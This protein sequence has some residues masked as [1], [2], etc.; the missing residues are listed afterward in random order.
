MDRYCFIEQAL[1]FW[2][3]I[4]SSFGEIK[5]YFSLDSVHTS[6]TSLIVYFG[7]GFSYFLSW[8]RS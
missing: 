4:G 1:G 3:G 7:L 8:Y 6:L 5:K 2:L